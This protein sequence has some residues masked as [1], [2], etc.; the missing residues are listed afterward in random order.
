MVILQEE[1]VIDKEKK[2]HIIKKGGWNEGGREG[3]IE[4]LDL[5]VLV[6]IP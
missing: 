4:A 1:E 5:S 6:D 3:A 2:M